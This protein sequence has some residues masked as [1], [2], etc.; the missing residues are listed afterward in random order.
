[1]VKNSTVILDKVTQKVYLDGMMRSK[2]RTDLR[3]QLKVGFSIGNNMLKLTIG[4][5]MRHCRVAILRRFLIHFTKEK[6]MSDRE[7]LELAAKA[8][9]F[10]LAPSGFKPRVALED[11]DPVYKTWNPLND[12][13]DAFQ[14]LVDLGL[15]INPEFGKGGLSVSY[16]LSHVI[17]LENWEG[18]A[19]SVRRSIVKAAAHIGSDL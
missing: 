14:L 2:P 5:K 17:Y 10:E 9:G 13:A 16:N 15:P 18:D 12:N 19:E 6:I 3:N 7:L 4:K 1:M 8:V 11:D